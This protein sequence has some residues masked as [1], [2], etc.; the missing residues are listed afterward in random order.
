V[1]LGRAA[2]K[3]FPEIEGGVT[4]AGPFDNVLVRLQQFTCGAALG[5]E[6]AE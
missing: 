4:A 5:N 1:R 2:R 6:T 3:A